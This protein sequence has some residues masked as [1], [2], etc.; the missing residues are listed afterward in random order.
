MNQ[1]SHHGESTYAAKERIAIIS[2]LRL[3]FAKQ[4]TAYQGIAAVDL[5]KA[6]VAELLSRSGIEKQLIEQLV[7]GQ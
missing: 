4:A 2:G 5:G 1:L 3:P 6:V 7:F